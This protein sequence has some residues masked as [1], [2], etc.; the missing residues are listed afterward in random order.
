MFSRIIVSL[1]LRLSSKWIIQLSTWR[2]PS[3]T[4]RRYLWLKCFS[5]Y[6]QL[7]RRTCWKTSTTTVCFTASMGRAGIW[8]YKYRI[9][10][11]ITTLYYASSAAAVLLTSL[12]ANPE[13]SFDQCL[14]ELRQAQDGRR[15]LQGSTYTVKPVTFFK[16]VQAVTLATSKYCNTLIQGG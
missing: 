16:W 4:I 8:L 3:Q 11:S 7:L 10:C 1:F 12:L 13:A 2:S 6:S 14:K 9:L 15:T 5:K